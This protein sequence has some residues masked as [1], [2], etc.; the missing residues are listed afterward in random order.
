MSL[1][2]PIR[3][4]TTHAA[5]RSRA[6]AVLCL[7]VLISIAAPPP[8]HAY[9]DPSSGSLLFQVIVA[10]VLGVV[11]SVRRWWARAIGLARGLLGR[12]AGR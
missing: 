12:V 10:A 1:S 5:K 9:I 6:R 2:V 4:R 11:L 7:F 8:A 3:I